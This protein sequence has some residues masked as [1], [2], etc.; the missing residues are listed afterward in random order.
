ME[1][2]EIEG[3]LADMCAEQ[4]PTVESFQR[5]IAGCQFAGIP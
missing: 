4:D 3:A 5:G 2:K 1:A